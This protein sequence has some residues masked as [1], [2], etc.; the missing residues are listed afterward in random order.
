MEQSHA[1][2]GA[3]TVSHSLDPWAASAVVAWGMITAVYFYVRVPLW[4][5]GAPVLSSLLLWAELFGVG[6][7]ALHI[8]A[9]WSLV[10]RHAP[11]LAPGQKADILITTWNEPVEMLRNTLL[12]AKQVR[13]VGKIW[14]LDD[15][16]RSEMRELSAELGVKYIGRVDRSHAKAGNL[17]NA[18]LHSDAELLAVFDCD[19]A[20]SPDFL[21]KTIGYFQDPEVAFVQ[22]PQDF[23][24]VDSF[25]HRGDQDA[26]EVWHEQTLFYRVIQPGK[27]RW[28]AAFFCGSCAVVRRAALDEIGGFATGTITEDLHTSLKIHKRGWRSVYHAEALAFGLSPASLDQYETQRLRWARGA[29]QVWSKEGFLFTKGLTLAQR[30]SYLGSTGTYF[31]GWQK[32]IVYFMPMVVMFTGWLP[33]VQI[34]PPFLFLFCLWMLSGMAVNEIVSRGYAKTAWMEEYNFFRY[35]TFIRATFAL[36]VPLNWRFIVTPKGKVTS[37]GLPTILLPQALVGVGALLALVFGTWLYHERFHLSPGV[38]AVTL[39]F[40]AYNLILAG[41]AL[42]FAMKHLR[43]RRGSHRFPLPMLVSLDVEGKRQ[44]VV[45]EDVSSDGMMLSGAGLGESA[46]IDGTIFLPGEELGFRGRVVRRSADGQQAGVQF[47]WSSAAEADALNACLYG[48]TLQ[49]DINSWSEVRRERHPLSMRHDS[50]RSCGRW[51]FA[52]AIADGQDRI[53]CVARREDDLGTRWRIVSYQRPGATAGIRLVSAGERTP[54]AGLFVTG[55]ERFGVGKGH[56]HISLLATD[57]RRVTLASHR[58]PQWSSA[59]TIDEHWVFVGP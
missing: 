49:W 43:Q 44:F 50:D 22:T 10:S 27:D 32:A 3:R 14:L 54:A 52:F 38:Y 35:F 2:L 47:S 58:Q 17:N 21:E 55:A 8:F 26:G 12:A 41:K 48:N 11:K 19:H 56:I 7:L 9:T 57:P 13:H 20:P 39:V 15:G 40:L 31:E 37:I 4:N 6:T 28:N 1:G 42:D 18:L 34:G 23:Y 36:V 33:I 46:T 53:P 45:A 25:Q 5:P 16:A 24:N 59:S 29:M 51:R 30:L